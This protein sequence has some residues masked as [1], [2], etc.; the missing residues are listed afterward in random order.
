MFLPAGDWGRSVN[1]MIDLFEHPDF[2]KMLKSAQGW[3]DQ[4]L[5]SLLLAGQAQ[6]VPLGGMAAEGLKKSCSENTKKGL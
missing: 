4:Q 3:A 1:N 6:G 2:K 5:V